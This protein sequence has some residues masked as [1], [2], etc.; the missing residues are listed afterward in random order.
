M[1]NIVHGFKRINDL[2][3]MQNRRLSDQMIINILTFLHVKIG[4]FYYAN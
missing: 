1:Q 4:R 2:N 3:K